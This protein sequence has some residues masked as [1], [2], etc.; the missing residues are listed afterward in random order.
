[1]ALQSSTPS[2]S[3][4]EGQTIDAGR[5]QLVRVLGEGAYGV[6]YLAIE[7]QEI[8]ASSSV[9]TIPKE[10]AVKVLPKVDSLSPVGQCQSREIVAHKIVCDHPGVLTLHD[11]IED[12]RFIFFV[13]DYCP[14]GDLYGMIVTRQAFHENDALLKSVFVQILDALQ[15]CHNKGI[16][17]R[18]LKPDNVFVSADDSKA[19][20]GDFG[21]STDQ[22]MSTNHRC[23]SSYYMSPECLGEDHVFAPFMNEIS[24]IWALGII[25]TNMVTGRNPWTRAT[26]RDAHFS[27][28]IQDPDGFIRDLLKM[29]ASAG[30]IFKRIF[31]FDPVQRI[32]L[33]EL[34]EAILAIDTFFPSLSEAD[35]AARDKNVVD[36]QQIWANS[37]QPESKHFCSRL[38]EDAWEAITKLDDGCSFVL[39]PKAYNTGSSS[40]PLPS[41]AFSSARTLCGSEDDISPKK[42]GSE[43]G[44]SGLVDA[45]VSK[46]ADPSILSARHR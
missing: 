35:S 7:Q 6:V 30:E 27:H 24:D 29:S 33:A 4:L 43:R 21:L 31:T 3:G 13:L 28:Y 39:H 41:T 42:G 32:S 36:T 26:T 10:Y 44:H 14:G 23:G 2:A 45:K 9:G 22:N 46:H 37:A 15:S 40:K 19:Y 5:L 17:H 18:D 16:Y 38:A 25:F 34:R 12:D 8:S 11:V 20:L 1:M